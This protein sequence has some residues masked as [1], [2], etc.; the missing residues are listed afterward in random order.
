MGKVK[1]LLAGFLFLGLVQVAGLA[2]A[3]LTVE[4]VLERMSSGSTRLEDLQADFVQTKVMALFDE[5]IVSSGKFYFR[6]PDKLILDTL[7]PEHQQLIINYNRVWLH[8]PELKQVHE[9]SLKQSKG[10]SA[11]FVGFGGSVSDI[12]DQFNTQLTGVETG[13]DGKQLYTLSLAPIPGTAAASPSLGLEKVVLTILEDR[14]YPVRTEIVQKNGDRSIYEYTNLKS[15][16]RL[17]DTR[18]TFVPPAGTQVIHHNTESG[19]SE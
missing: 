18:F 14:W 3:Q 13:A 12:R 1:G 10:L 7:S 11:L 6:N 9:L 17:P 2:A 5:K 15:N 16:L 19:A 4:Q 8:Y